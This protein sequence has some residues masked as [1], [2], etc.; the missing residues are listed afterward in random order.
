[1]K[2][3]TK[4]QAIIVSA[5]TGVTACNFGDLHEAVEKKLGRPVWTHQFAD[6]EVT[7][8]IR[9]AFREDFLAICYE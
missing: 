8:E 9:K 3:L 5:Y 7:E 4:E 6:K 2:K 1:M